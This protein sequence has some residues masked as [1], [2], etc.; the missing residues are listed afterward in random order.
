MVLNERFKRKKAIFMDEEPEKFWGL[1]SI[2]LKKRSQI[3]GI[4]KKVLKTIEKD[5]IV[6]MRIYI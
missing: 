3:D 5:V 2:C 4:Y 1:K 6:K